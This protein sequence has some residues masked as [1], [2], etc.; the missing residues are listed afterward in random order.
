VSTPV[1]AAPSPRL[2]ND[3]EMHI[4][5]Q[6]SRTLPWRPLVVRRLLL[7]LIGAIVLSTIAFG[8][9]VVPMPPHRLVDT[10]SGIKFTNGV[11]P[12]TGCNAAADVIPVCVSG[13]AHGVTN[14]EEAALFVYTDGSTGATHSGY[15]LRFDQT[16]NL[17]LAYGNDGTWISNTG[18]YGISNRSAVQY[19]LTHYYPNGPAVDAYGQGAIQAAIWHYANDLV[20]SSTNPTTQ[21]NYNAILADVNANGSGYNVPFG[22]IGEPQMAADPIANINLLS[23]TTTSVTIHDTEVNG[24]AITS[25]A[26]MQIVGDTSGTARFTANGLTS[27]AVTTTGGSATAS[28]TATAPG[29]VT[30]NAVQSAGPDSVTAILW[31]DATHQPIAQACYCYITNLPQPQ[32]ANVSFSVVG[33]AHIVLSSKV[34]DLTSGAVLNPASNALAVGVSPGDQIRID[35]IMQNTGT[36][37]SSGSTNIQTDI[38][39]IT[40]PDSLIAL[41][42]MSGWSSLS[43]S[44]ATWLAGSIGVGGSY[45]ASLTGTVARTALP[46]STSPPT[47]CNRPVDSGTGADN[48]GLRA[49]DACLITMPVNGASVTATAANNGSTLPGITS[50]YQGQSGASIQAQGGDSLTYTFTLTNNGNTQLNNLSFIDVLRGNNLDQLTNVVV[51]NSGSCDNNCSTTPSPPGTFRKVSWPTV[52][53]APGAFA[54]FTLTATAGSQCSAGGGMTNPGS[55]FAP[56]VVLASGTSTVN[57]MGGGVVKF[58]TVRST[59]STSPV[60]VKGGQQF[61]YNLTIANDPTSA[62][63]ITN[64]YIIFQPPA[65]PAGKTA[66]T[67]QGISPNPVNPAEQPGGYIAPN[68]GTYTTNNGTTPPTYTIPIGVP[69]KVSQAESFSISMLAPPDMSPGQSFTPT[70]L[71]TN[72]PSDSQGGPVGATCSA[73]V[74]PMAFNTSNNGQPGSVSLEH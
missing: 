32:T 52:N 26:I 73:I 58:D 70:L 39:S 20:V 64:L 30:V 40:A 7:L 29:T 12:N 44:N 1:I 53:L 37:A 57:I 55:V 13:T 60:T 3:Q 9:G 62:D 28:I 22:G 8:R 19:I 25:G 67:L 46:D 15:C 66:F 2:Y 56:G 43:G 18:D 42:S 36:A 4:P 48:D 35:T 41:T 51:G 10:M 68:P 38:G 27:L 23:G 11:L 45:T 31:S 14:T 24:T 17:A 61:T 74:T 16:L 65:V 34:T 59:V 54:S 63:D 72:Q 33:F 21:A 50:P 47:I 71:R 6:M 5:A 49:P 69:L